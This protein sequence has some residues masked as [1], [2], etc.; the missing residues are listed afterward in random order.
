MSRTGE[1]GDKIVITLTSDGKRRH[2]KW[3]ENYIQEDSF[4]SVLCRKCIGSAH[5]EYYRDKLENTQEYIPKSTQPEETQET[6]GY[7]LSPV[8]DE[9]YRRATMADKL[10]GETV[11]VRGNYNTYKI[12]TVCYDSFSFFSV[13][14]G[15]RIHK[16]SKHLAIRIGVYVLEDTKLEPR[17]EI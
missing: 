11:L 9:Y 8:Y 10:L 4:C 12:G 1:W 3:C 5:C 15:G 16:Y 6:L 7:K 17:V 2:K 13:E 14:Y